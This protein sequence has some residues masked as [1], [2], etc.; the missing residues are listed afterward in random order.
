MSFIEKNLMN[1]EK[2][3]HRARLHWIVFLLPGIL[4]VMAMPFFIAGGKTTPVGIFFMLLSISTGIASFISYS[5]SEFGITNKRVMVKIGFIR[6]SS[7]EVLLTKVEGIQVNQGFWGRILGYGSLVVSGTGGTKDPFYK[8]SNP[9]E[10]RKKAQEQIA[11][12]Q[13]AR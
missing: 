3:I 2:I 1:G 6:R 5:T 12:V 9:L 11:I 10:F 4:F 13:E 8:I 7:M